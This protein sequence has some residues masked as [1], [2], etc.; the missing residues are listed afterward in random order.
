MF[1]VTSLISLIIYSVGI[2]IVNK[3]PNNEQNAEIVIENVSLM[4]Y[5]E[6]HD[7]NDYNMSRKIRL[8]LKKDRY[9]P[10]EVDFAVKNNNNCEPIN[11]SM[12]KVELKNSSIIYNTKNYNISLDTVR[13]TYGEYCRHHIVILLKMDDETI[14]YSKEA[15]LYFVQQNI[16]IKVFGY[17]NMNETG[18]DYRTQGTVLCSTIKVFQYDCNA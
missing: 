12:A 18:D 7:S 1:F 10:L 5:L 11:Y 4:N 9:I 2:C 8:Y 13:L 15:L 3:K 16:S 14:D 6:L 17:S